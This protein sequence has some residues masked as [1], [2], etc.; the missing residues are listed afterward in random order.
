VRFAKGIVVYPYHNHSQWH[1]RDWSL[2]WAKQSLLAICPSFANY[3]T[4]ARW[5]VVDPENST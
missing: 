3:S 2:L 5:I 4:T 1:D